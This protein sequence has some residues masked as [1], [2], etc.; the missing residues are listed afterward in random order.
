M[1]T[2]NII[3]YDIK[4]TNK[5]EYTRTKRMFYYYLKKIKNLNYLTKSAIITENPEQILKIIYKFK[6]IEA[7]LIKSDEISNLN[8]GRSTPVPN[9][10]A[11]DW[12]LQFK[13]A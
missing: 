9:K 10:A 11:K 8:S 13:H 6:N 1:V 12:K 7:F 3:I 4:Y 5:K 2:Y